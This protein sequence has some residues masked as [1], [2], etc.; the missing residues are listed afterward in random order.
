LDL[1][2]FEVGGTPIPNRGKEL[3]GVRVEFHVSRVTLGDF[4][5]DLLLFKGGHPNSKGKT[6]GVT[7]QN[8]L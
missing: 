6:P 4:G 7:D 8:R 2:L 3:Q 1:L 5:S